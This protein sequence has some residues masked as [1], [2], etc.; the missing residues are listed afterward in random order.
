MQSREEGFAISINYK[1]ADCIGLLRVNYFGDTLWTRE[2]SSNPL[3]GDWAEVNE[4]NDGF[5]LQYAILIDSTWGLQVIKTD[6][7]GEIQWINVI[8]RIGNF[9][10]SSCQVDDGSIFIS[11]NQGMYV[12]VTKISNTGNLIWSKKY[13]GLGGGTIHGVGP[14]T[15]II[16][17][18]NHRLIIASSTSSS[19]IIENN[20]FIFEI[21]LDGQMVWGKI[22]GGENMDQLIF[23][24]KI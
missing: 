16:E 13:Y 20:A 4:V 3:W 6:Q 23:I 2:F 17:T 7:A 10:L 22:L 12:W 1:D 8:L 21:D 15:N 5:L 9:G 11:G 14:Q 19:D 24:G 18:F